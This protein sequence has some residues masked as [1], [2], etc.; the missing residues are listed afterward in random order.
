MYSA[1]FCSSAHNATLELQLKEFMAREFSS[2]K[3]AQ[4]LAT[5]CNHLIFFLHIYVSKDGVEETKEL[6]QEGFMS[7]RSKLT[8]ALLIQFYEELLIIYN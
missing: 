5:A 7:E 4:R 2:A 6:C 1:L 3:E 8:K